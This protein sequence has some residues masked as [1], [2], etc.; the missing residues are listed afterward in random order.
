MW[1][2]SN[3]FYEKYKFVLH[4][5]NMFFIRDDLF[6]K[7]DISYNNPLENFRSKWGGNI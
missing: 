3:I 1:L 4:T 6:E 7:L 5:G 2:Y